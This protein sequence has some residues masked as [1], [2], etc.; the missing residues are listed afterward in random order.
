MT[1]SYLSSP[2][3]LHD[4]YVLFQ[5]LVNGPGTFDPSGDTVVWSD[6]SGLLQT[7]FRTGTPAPGMPSGILF[8][9]ARAV[10][11]AAGQMAISADT[12]Y[13]LGGIGEPDSRGVWVERNGSLRLVAQSNTDAPGLFPS[14]RFYSFDKPAIDASGRVS[15]VATTLSY[16]AENQLVVRKG[17]WAEDSQFRLRLIASVDSSM[18]LRPRGGVSPADEVDY[19][20]QRGGVGGLPIGYSDSGQLAYSMFFG[21]YLQNYGYWEQ[22]AYVATADA[23]GVLIASDFDVDGAVDADDLAAWRGA[24]GQLTRTGDASRDFQN[25]GFDFLAWQRQLGKVATATP[26]AA[27]PEPCGALLALAPILGVG[28]CGRDSRREGAFRL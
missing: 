14:D 19:L 20:G 18:D 3:F 15:F 4:G 27:V 6:R 7:V 25:D 22:A 12:T 9:N 26:V 8:T 1:I 17:I 21:G 10:A 11:N 16:D 28:I 5:G 24:F 13:G 23:N 2:R